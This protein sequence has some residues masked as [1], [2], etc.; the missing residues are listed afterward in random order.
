MIS[1]RLRI[2]SEWPKSGWTNTLNL[3]TSAVPSTATCRPETWRRRKSSEPDSTVKT[4]NGLWTKWPGTF[5]NTT[6]QWSPLLLPG[7]RYGTFN[8]YG[9]IFFKSDLTLVCNLTHYNV[10]SI[11]RIFAAFIQKVK[12]YITLYSI[13]HQHLNHLVSCPTVWFILPYMSLED[14]F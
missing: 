8:I 6:P 9:P 3:F 4:S 12:S 13:Q 14:W 5:P 10:L 1:S 2:W 7:E 11:L